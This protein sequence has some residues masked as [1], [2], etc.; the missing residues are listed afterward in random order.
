MG[1]DSLFIESLHED[2]FSLISNFDKHPMIAILWFARQ[3][4]LRLLSLLS[5]CGGLLMVG[6]DVTVSGSLAALRQGLLDSVSDRMVTE[7]SNRLKSELQER[8]RA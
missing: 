4:V 1:C 5:W 8:A 6:T 2:S 7:I 3:S